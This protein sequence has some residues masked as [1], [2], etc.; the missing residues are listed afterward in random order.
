[1]GTN[2]G[3]VH[4]YKTLDWEVPG[5]MLDDTNILFGLFNFFTKMLLKGKRWGENKTKVFL[6]I[7]PENSSSI[8]D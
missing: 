1:M 5:Y 8:E 6:F 2:K 3:F 7:R 4:L